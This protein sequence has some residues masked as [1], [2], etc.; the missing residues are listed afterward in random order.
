M[1][2]QFNEEEVNSL[3]Q[4]EINH[5]IRASNLHLPGYTEANA[6]QALLQAA[7]NMLEF[8]QNCYD[9]YPDYVDNA[10]FSINIG[11]QSIALI[12]GGPQ[13]QGLCEMIKCIADDNGYEVD[14]ETCTVLE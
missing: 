3:M 6:L 13:F 7:N 8:T 12:L 11:G 5:N 1:S 4:N 14:F 10:Q 2:N 9:Q